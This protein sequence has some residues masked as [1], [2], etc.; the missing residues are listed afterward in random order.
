MVNDASK[1]KTSYFHDPES[2]NENNNEYDNNNI[3][4]IEY[5]VNDIYNINQEK[6][7]SPKNNSDNNDE[8]HHMAL[9]PKG[10]DPKPAQNLVRFGP[11]YRRFGLEPKSVRTEPKNRRFGSV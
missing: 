4:K 9:W 7:S 1:P 2:N 6:E 10:T 8:E 3:W 5:D 11:D